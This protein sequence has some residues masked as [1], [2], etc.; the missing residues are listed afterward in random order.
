MCLVSAH[1]KQP[2]PEHQ[3]FKNWSGSSCFMVA[4]IILEGLLQSETMNGLRYKWLIGYGDSS[5]Y[6]AVSQQVLSYDQCN[7]KVECANYVIKCYRN[8]MEDLCK[9]KLEYKGQNALS[10]S[11]TKRVTHGAWTA[12]RSH[13]VTKNVEALRHD[14]R[15]GLCHCFGDH[16]KCVSNTKTKK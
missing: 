8:R 16:S 9:Q 14:L 15:N 13:S 4:D 10:T 11:L 1:K 5:V 12:I 2:P 7:V 6:N 3:C